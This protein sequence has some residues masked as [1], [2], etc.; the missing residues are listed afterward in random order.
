MAAML[1]AEGRVGTTLGQFPYEITPEGDIAI[2]EDYN[3]NEVTNGDKT[4]GTLYQETDPIGKAILAISSL[5][6]LP[7]RAAAQKYMPEGGSS[8][9]V[10]IRIPKEQFPEEDYQK[11]VKLMEGRAKNGN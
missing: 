4:A 5:G 8:R 9:P 11:L 10:D 7:L 6:Y 3:F 1:S 2:R